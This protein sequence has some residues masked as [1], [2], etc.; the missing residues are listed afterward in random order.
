M[1]GSY[2]INLKTPLPSDRGMG[3]SLIKIIVAVFL[4]AL[5]TSSCSKKTQPADTVTPVEL[6][7]SNHYAALFYFSIFGDSMYTPPLLSPSGDAWIMRGQEP[8]YSPVGQFSFWAKP[9]FAATHGDGTI[10]NNY[11][12]YLNGDPAQTNNA[13]LD[14]HADLITEAGVDLI[15]VDFTNGARDFPNGPAYISATTALCNRWQ[16]RKRQGLPIPQIAFFVQNAEVLAAVEQLYLTK[17]DESIF[18]KY[19]GKKLLLV[20]D[21]L[22]NGNNADPNQPAVPTTGK[23]SNYTT[24]HCWGLDNSG[25][26]WQFK[27][28]S[29]TPPPAFHYKGK[30]EQMSAP[31]STQA[32][33]MTTDGINIMPGAQGRENG[34][35]FKKYM[36]AATR[37]QPTFVF[38]HSWNEWAAGNWGESQQKP[39]FVDQW[40]EEYSS[41][42]EP[43]EGGHGDLYYKMM[44]EEIGKFKGRRE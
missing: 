5:L 8:H 27:V 19:L 22:G 44:K 29:A 25:K 24:R 6:V 10:K 26:R 15:V 39:S 7:D 16:E 32:N 18:F 42:I 43:M 38:I 36:A 37:V 20:G 2:L 14:Y 35:Y 1:K 40:L 12:F 4:S 13:L 33:Y 34:A 3:E 21:A 17:Y 31:I 30:P 23:F 41:D 9:L 11:R 28:N